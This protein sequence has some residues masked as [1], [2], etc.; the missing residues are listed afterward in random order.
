MSLANSF[1]IAS[2]Q[3][4]VN[5]VQANSKEEYSLRKE[6]EEYNVIA[7]HEILTAENFWALEYN[8]LIIWKS[9]KDK[10]FMLYLLTQ[11]VLSI[12]ETSAPSERNFSTSRRLVSKLRTSLKRTKVNDLMLISEYHYKNLYLNN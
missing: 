5:V 8:H 1:L 6:V 9:Y 10:F 11:R 12:P 7:P 2:S 4:Q 3:K